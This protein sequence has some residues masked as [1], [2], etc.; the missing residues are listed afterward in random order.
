[1]TP[2]KNRWTKDAIRKLRERLG[3]KQKVAA[4]AIGVSKTHWSN[5]E[6]GV[7][8]PNRQTV[9]LLD[10]LAEGGRASRLLMAG[11]YK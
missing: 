6:G 8:T 1:M 7:R 2:K 3:V 10:M 9:I 11:A 5:L 4:E